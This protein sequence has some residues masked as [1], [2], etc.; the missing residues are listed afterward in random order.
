MA[1]PEE[2]TALT[3]FRVIALKLVEACHPLSSGLVLRMR[4][5]NQAHEVI[6]GVTYSAGG[7]RLSW[8]AYDH[9][10]TATPASVIPSLRIAYFVLVAIMKSGLSMSP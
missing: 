10:L 5:T 4:C 7:E 3:A 6:H 1:T 9:Y 2:K 8:L